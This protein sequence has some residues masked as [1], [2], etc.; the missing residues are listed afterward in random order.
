MS[1]A[2]RFNTGKP[3]LGYIFTFPRALAAF[4]KVCMYGASKYRAYNYLRG[5]PLSQYV[6]CMSRHLAA[7]MSGEDIDTGN[8]DDPNDNGSGQPHLAHVVWN[9]L[10][11]CEMALSQPHRDDRPCTVMDSQDAET[12]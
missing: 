5:A 1:D 10:A 3:E 2:L 11:L 7:W 8:P 12:R 4:A 6:N 9:A